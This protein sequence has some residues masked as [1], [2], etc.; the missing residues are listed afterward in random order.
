VPRA[1]TGILGLTCAFAIWAGYWSTLAAVPGAPV[2][3]MATGEQS[4]GSAF[5]ARPVIDKYCVTCHNDRLK[6]AGLAFER[7]DVGRVAA[8]PETWEKVVR[9]LRA[10]EMPPS[11]APRPDPAVYG[12]MTASLE[13]ALDAAAALSPNPGRVAVHRLN[14]S[15]YVNAVR[16]LLALDIDARTMLWADEPDQEGFENVASVLSM[17][18]ALLDSYISASRKIS[19]LAMGSASEP[20]I[21]SFDISRLL[22]QDERMSDALPF[23]SQ[24]GASIRHTFPRDGEYQIKVRLKRQLYGYILGMGE[25][26]QFDVR[27]DG[28]LVKR[29]TVGGEAKG[30]PMPESWVGDTQGDPEFEDYMHTADAGLELRMPIKTGPHD[31]GVSFVRRFREPEGVVQPPIRMSGRSLNEFFHDYPGVETVTVSGPFASS[32]AGE[33]SP[34]RRKIFACRPKNEGEEDPCAKRILSTLAQRAYRRPVN[35]RDV[36]TLVS[37]YKEGRASGGFDAGIQR[38]LERILVAPSFLF[39]VERE[40]ESASPGTVFRLG[41]LDLASRLS[42]FLWSSI[43]DEELLASAIAG[44]LSQTAELEKQVRRMLADPRARALVDNFVDQWL[45]LTKLESIGP[46]AEVYPEFDENL[47]DAMR[48]ETREFVDDQL[49]ND[50][51]VLEMLTANYSYVNERLAAHYGIQGVYG[52][53]FRKVTFTDGRRGGLLGQASL[54][55]VTSY[56][57]RT[58]VVL[59]GKWLLATLLGSPPPAPPETVPPLKEAGEDGQP[60]SLRK[61]MQE[62]RDNPV[63]A[64]CHDRMDSLGFSLENF[65]ALGK[66]R[67]MAD[68]ETVDASALLPDGTRFDGISGLR[69]VLLSQKEDYVRTFSAKLLGY[70]VGRGIEYYDQPAIRQIAREGAAADSKWSSLILAVVRSTPFRMGRVAG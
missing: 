54:L 48:Q 6:T 51:S 1:T 55:T 31:I 64:T 47:R 10:G 41:D 68:G 18:P 44:K 30:R 40:P 9:K 70:A 58:S 42:F 33:D 60:R 61:R 14:R 16:D 8:A 26:H 53:Q 39:R 62:H 20:V 17:S 28:A 59:R 15:E 35:D 32:G 38:G 5:S 52:N 57:N 11:G 37:F 4:A 21:E 46:D 56:P 13:K 65:D 63:C 7:L 67:S 34:S 29:F 2:S 66:W 24:G 12:A 43:P 23:G 27:L 45:Q 36:E 22:V 25:P 69:R 50:R 19:R 3:G 49:R